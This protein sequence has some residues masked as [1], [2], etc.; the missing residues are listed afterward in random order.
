MIKYRKGTYKYQ[1]AEDYSVKT[2]ITGH[3]VDKEY[4]A[5]DLDG[6]LTVK[7]GYAW[8]GASGPTFDTKSAMRPSLCH[9]AFCQM[10]N[11]KQIPFDRTVQRAV[12]DFFYQQLIEDGMWSWRAWYWRKAV[13]SAD[14]GNPENWESDETIYTA[15]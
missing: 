5:L 1:L 12:H 15:P 10:L 4:Y 6:T 13:I 11:R 2:P 14:A 7:R 8:D 9:D 3:V